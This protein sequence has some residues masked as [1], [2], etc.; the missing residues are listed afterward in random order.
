MSRK[1]GVGIVKRDANAASRFG[2]EE[3]DKIGNEYVSNIIVYAAQPCEVNA[4]RWPSYAQNY[5]EGKTWTEV[6]FRIKVGRYTNYYIAVVSPAAHYF[7]SFGKTAVVDGD[8]ARRSI[9]DSMFVS[10]VKLIKHRELVEIRPIPSLV[11]LMLIDGGEDLFS[12]LVSHEFNAASDGA[13]VL[14]A[15]DVEERNLL[16]LLPLSATE[17]AGEISARER[18]NEIIE[19]GAK[20]VS[21]FA[22]LDAEVEEWREPSIKPSFI[23]R[24]VSIEIVDHAYWV[25][26]L[27]LRDIA[28]D[29]VEVLLR[30]PDFE[31]RTLAWMG[32]FPGVH[33]V[34]S[35]LPE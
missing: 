11:R 27:I 17:F 35:G 10:D 31:T 18:V 16:S 32:F 13:I 21:E 2:W 28:V 20:L 7:N 22:N 15:G 4:P 25:K 34:S 24:L 14:D 23:E 3:L 9:H 33:D 6:S 1:I 29:G 19:S 26:S 12:D 5:L 8:V 30:P